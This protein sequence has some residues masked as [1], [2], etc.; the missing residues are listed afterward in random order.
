M[1]SQAEGTEESK[2]KKK[3]PAQ[4]ESESYTHFWFSSTGTYYSIIIKS[5]LGGS[6]I[7]T[8][9]TVRY[10]IIWHDFPGTEVPVS[11]LTGRDS[12]GPGF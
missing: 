7:G 3:E 12:R 11:C 5:V 6:S 10:T 8:D 4:Q 9:R 2:K 1:S